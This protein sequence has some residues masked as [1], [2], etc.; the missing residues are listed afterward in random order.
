ML[1]KR[2]VAGLAVIALFLGSFFGF[3]C[4]DDESTSN[5]NGDPAA[6]EPAEDNGDTTPTE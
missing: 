3:A 4:D 1:P 5:G 2:W 6:T